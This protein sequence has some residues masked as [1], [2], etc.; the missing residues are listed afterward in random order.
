MGRNGA[1]SP[2]RSRAPRKDVGGQE[3]DVQVPQQFQETACAG[4]NS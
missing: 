2:E 1:S 4:S 3:F